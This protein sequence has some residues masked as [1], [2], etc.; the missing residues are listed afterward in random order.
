MA[1]SGWRAKE[2]N[3]KGCGR[4]RERIICGCGR[5]ICR[6]TFI[7]ISHLTAKNRPR[8]FRC[9]VNKSKLESVNAAA[10]IITP[11]LYNL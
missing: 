11:R 4:G 6:S 2:R 5:I 9:Y 8:F 7:N 3:G 10:V 1:T